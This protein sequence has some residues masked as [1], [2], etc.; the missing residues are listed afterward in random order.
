MWHPRIRSGWNGLRFASFCRI[1]ELWAP[2]WLLAHRRDIDW[3][4]HLR[5]SCSRKLLDPR[6][7][8]LMEIVG[9]TARPI[10][11]I[12]QKLLHQ[13]SP[14]EVPEISAFTE[15]NKDLCISAQC[16][17]SK[18]GNEQRREDQVLLQIRSRAV[19]AWRLMQTNCQNS[20]QYIK[21]MFWGTS[22]FAKG[23]KKAPWNKFKISNYR[24]YHKNVKKQLMKLVQ[25]PVVK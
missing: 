8:C 21:W 25:V 7:T 3:D 23:S 11:W 10:P 5:P 1:I 18:V 16:I 24:Q 4:A 19:Q 20:I 6:Q 2:G 9:P 17:H 12:W 15:E 13:L 22:Q 14:V